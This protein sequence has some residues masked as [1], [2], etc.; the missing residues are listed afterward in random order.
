[1]EAGR[2]VARLLGSADFNADRMDEYLMS[3]ARYSSE[4]INSTTRNHVLSSGAAAAFALL[5]DSRSAQ[6]ATTLAGF[7][8]NFGAKEGAADSGAMQKIWQVNSTDPRAEHSAMSGATAG[9][10]DL[11]SNGMWGP[12]DPGGGVDQNAGC[13]C[14]LGFR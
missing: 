6:I 5:M 7:S 13:Q 4:N 2:R 3:H 11:F 12:G 14:S 8:V 10:D 1:M 9:I